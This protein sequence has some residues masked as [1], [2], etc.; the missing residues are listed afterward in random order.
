MMIDPLIEPMKA[1]IADDH[2]LFRGALRQA[3]QSVVDGDI[4]EAENFEQTM[5]LLEEHPEVD[6]VF[7]DLNMPGNEGFTG[8][9]A[10][11]NAFPSAQAV[12]VSAE[13]NP[14]II[15]K[16]LDFGASGYIPKSSDLNDIAAAISVV[17]DGELWL[18]E[19][20]KEKVDTVENEE[21]QA[22]A[23]NPASI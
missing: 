18:P 5:M 13:E 1:I 6:L 3:V 7:L 16:A 17:L 22:R 19:G 11:R 20:T 15:R 9:T 14:T 2:P 23:V 21:G 10:I 4:Y 12:M 8:L